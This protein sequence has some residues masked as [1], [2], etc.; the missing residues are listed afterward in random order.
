M[1][2]K[3]M[4]VI[5]VTSDGGSDE[6]VAKSRGSNEADG[7]RRQHLGVGGVHDEQ[8]QADKNYMSLNEFEW[9]FEIE[10][11]CWW[12]TSRTESVC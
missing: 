8:D 9:K 4:V 2:K 11:A 12:H 10:A 5:D 1:L 7:G 6:K 3:S